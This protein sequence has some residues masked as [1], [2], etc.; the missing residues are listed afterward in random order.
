MSNL[1]RLL[2]FQLKIISFAIGVVLLSGCYHKIDPMTVEPAGKIKLAG[3]FT[4][5]MVLQRD[6]ALP[7]WGTADPG[8]RITVKFGS[9]IKHTVSDPEG[10]WQVKLP[11]LKVNRTPSEL[12]VFGSET[13]VIKNILVG[14]VWPGIRTIKYCA[15]CDN[16]ERP[17]LLRQIPKSVYSL[18]EEKESN[19]FLIVAGNGK[20]A[21]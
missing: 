16:A 18:M 2:I 6:M 4:D 20:Y 5:N 11:P 12:K 14:D 1:H 13:I 21:A 9:S 7:V 17:L 15:K 3:I 19:P 10:K 8:K